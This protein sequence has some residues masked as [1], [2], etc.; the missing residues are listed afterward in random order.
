MHCVSMLLVLE[1][2]PYDREER[3]HYRKCSISRVK[4]WWQ[5]R[6]MPGGSLEIWIENARGQESVFQESVPSRR[7]RCASSDPA[8]V[9]SPHPDNNVQWSR[10]LQEDPLLSLELFVHEDHQLNE[11]I[12]IIR[13]ATFESWKDTKSVQ[14]ATL[15]RGRN[16]A[17]ADVLI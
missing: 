9:H 17:F 6:Q 16:M 11:S 4:S 13:R 15:I 3:E 10:A 1:R 8:R 14:P 5:L 12:I 7:N 2:S